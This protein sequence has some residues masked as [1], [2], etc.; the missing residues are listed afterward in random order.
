MTVVCYY[1]LR[2]GYNGTIHE[3]VIILVC[4]NKM[5]SI[6]WRYVANISAV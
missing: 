1:I 4:L 3:L 2:I 5:E 6:R